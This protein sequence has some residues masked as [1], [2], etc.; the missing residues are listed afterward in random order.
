LGTISLSLERRESGA[1]RI[2]DEFALHECPCKRHAIDAFGDHLHSCT[3]HAGATMGAHILTAVQTIQAGYRTDRKNLPHSH[4][5]KKADLVIKYSRLAGVQN[6]ILDMSLRHEFHG[7][8]ADP[9]R[10]GE[11]SHADVNSALDAA[12]I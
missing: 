1:G 5:L 12:V 7:S 8:R 6:V 2:I 3:Q 10:N 11:A 9:H 4:G